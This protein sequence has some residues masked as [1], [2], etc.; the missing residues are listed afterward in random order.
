MPQ[1]KGNVALDSEVGEKR[2]VLK[3]QAHAARAT[4]QVNT[5]GGVKQHAPI[6]HDATASGR[7]ESSNGAQGHRLAGDVAGK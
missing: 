2:V 7:V 5:G 3:K 6:E 4:R 1:A